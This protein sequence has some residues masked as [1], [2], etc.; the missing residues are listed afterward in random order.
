MKNEE[1]KI[2]NI[3]VI[4]LHEVRKTYTIYADSKTEA[5]KKAVQGDWDDSSPDRPTGNIAK[6]TI[7]RKGVK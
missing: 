2:F 4:E 5:N 3:E 1:K 6:V 7:V